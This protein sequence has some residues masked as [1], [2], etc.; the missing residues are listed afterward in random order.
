[1][2]RTKLA[3][4]AITVVIAG[5][6]AALAVGTSPGSAKS[7]A[8]FKAA[9]IYVGPHNDGG[10]SQAHDQGRLAVQKALGSKVE[11]TYKENVPEGPQVSQVIE[12]L[13]R[14]GNK[15]IFG[16]S[17]GFQDA[18][19]AAAA[20][21]PDVKFEM[22]TGT[23]MSKNMAEYYGAGED[24]IYLS[25]IAAGAATKSGTV[26]YVVPFAIPEVIRHTNAFAL[27]VQKSHPGAKVKIIWTNSWFAPDKEKKAAESLH[28]SGADVLG[29]NVDSP[30]AGQY[31]E[32]AGIPWV[33]YDSNAQ[34]FAK[35][36][37]LTA[38]VYNWGPY[39]TK[40]VT[41]AMNGTWKTGNYYGNIKDGFTTLAPYGKNV[42][43]KT[44]KLIAQQRALIVSGKWNEFQG[45]IYDQS[46]KV[47]IKA[48]KRPSFNDLYS[49]DYLVRGVIGS[50]KG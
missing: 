1:M 25:G 16:T 29:Q 22:A 12:S 4:A 3:L 36:S 9:W 33:G 13:I 42:S 2:T 8:T 20:K 30:S 15:I 31:S 34:K 37:W 14:D 27:G 49:M 21:H 44:K 10:W 19:F 40:R 28:S 45:P 6:A 7:S 23:K 18:M 47:R 24:A 32:S 48:G 50:A 17:F 41:A 46:G 39:Y 43:A 26:G 5:A 38:A 35:N 11:T